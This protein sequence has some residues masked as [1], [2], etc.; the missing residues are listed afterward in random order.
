VGTSGLKFID[1]DEISGLD[2][3]EFTTPPAGSPNSVAIQSEEVWVLV[4]TS[5]SNPLSEFVKIYDDDESPKV[6]LRT[7]VHIEEG[8]GPYKTS[9]PVPE[10]QIK[11]VP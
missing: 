1:V 11:E 4:E 10:V 8:K 9:S 7:L 2:N 6:S 3:L 5:A